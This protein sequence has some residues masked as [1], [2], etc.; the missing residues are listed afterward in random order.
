[1]NITGLIVNNRAQALVEVALVLLSSDVIS[2][3]S[4]CFN[5]LSKLNLEVI[6]LELSCYLEPWCYFLF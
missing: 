6:H 5:A 1:M 4:G 3:L 2:I